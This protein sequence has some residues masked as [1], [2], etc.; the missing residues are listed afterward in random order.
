MSNPTQ[1]NVKSRT[2]EEGQKQFPPKAK[3]TPKPVNPPFG[4]K[5][6]DSNNPETKIPMRPC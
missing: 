3:Y 4:L 5:T 6:V 2:M 1:P